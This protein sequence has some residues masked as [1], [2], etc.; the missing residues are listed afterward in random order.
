MRFRRWASCTTVTTAKPR[1]SGGQ[2]AHAEQVGDRGQTQAA[3]SGL[4]DPTGVE[5]TL[6]NLSRE[7]IIYLIPEFDTDEG[8]AEVLR[9]LREEI[10][11][12]Q[13]AGWYTKTRSATQIA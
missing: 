6:F 5:L 11:E 3:F 10:L 4:A 7:P 1:E 12:E 2:H 9:D 8:V 13:L